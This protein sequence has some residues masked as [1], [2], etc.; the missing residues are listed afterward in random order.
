MDKQSATLHIAGLVVVRTIAWPTAVFL[1]TATQ[2]CI[3][4][5]MN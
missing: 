2:V 1:I 5:N 3:K 4:I